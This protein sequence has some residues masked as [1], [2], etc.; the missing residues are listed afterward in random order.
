MRPRLDRRAETRQ[1]N[2]DLRAH[3]PQER[4]YC[5]C[6]SSLPRGITS[7]LRLSVKREPGRRRARWPSTSLSSWRR[8]LVGSREHPRIEPVLLGRPTPPGSRSSHGGGRQRWSVRHDRH[9]AQLNSR[10]RPNLGT[11]SPGCSCLTRPRPQRPAQAIGR[12]P[13]PEPNHTQR[14]I[15]QRDFVSRPPGV[16]DRWERRRVCRLALAV[17][18]LNKN[19]AIQLPPSGAGRLI[20]TKA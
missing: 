14:S 13:R 8:P 18:N 1:G 4:A 9:F 11:L 3:P 2:R 7:P 10:P 6:R 16:D 19:A 15:A 5:L 12:R 20:A 17:S